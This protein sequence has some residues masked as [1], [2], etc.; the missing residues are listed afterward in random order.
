MKSRTLHRR[1]VQ[2]EQALAI[3]IAIVIIWYVVTE[4][5]RG[6]FDASRFFMYFTTQTG[7]LFILYQVEFRVVEETVARTISSI[8]RFSVTLY[9]LLILP[10]YWLLVQPPGTWEV[11]NGWIVIHLILPL[12]T[13][14]GWLLDP[15]NL[16]RG[17]WWKWLLWSLLYPVL[18]VVAS[19]IRGA[20]DN[21]YPYPF[22][23]GNTTVVAS[24]IGGLFASI[25]LIGSAL[26]CWARRRTIRKEL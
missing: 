15:P 2:L 11:T 4:V 25:I 26:L 5:V 17:A 20:F 13:L 3:A 16:P 7:V 9:A 12:V 10:V 8:I 19:L 21:W 1:F 23:E 24:Y 14:L 18:F 6:V 22:F